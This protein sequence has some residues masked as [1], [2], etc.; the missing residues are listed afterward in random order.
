M[1]NH[2]RMLI[3]CALFAA[4]TAVGA[5]LR[6]PAGAMSITLQFFFTAMAGML[7]YLPGDA[8]KIAAAALLA[9][10]LL[11]ALPRQQA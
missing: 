2:T 9:K 5:F 3:L 7:V 6:L 1:R 8:V 11:R 10:P 4:L